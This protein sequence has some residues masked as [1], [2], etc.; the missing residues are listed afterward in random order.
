VSRKALEVVQQRLGGDVVEVGDHLGDAC[1]TVRSAALRKA[2]EIC[3]NDPAL[4]CDLL[5]D[6]VGVDH[7]RRAERFD[8]VYN[9][10]SMSTRERIRIKTSVAEDQAVPTVSDLW[11]SANWAEREVYDLFGVPF[12]DHPNLKRILC[13]HE[14][15]GHALRKD[16]PIGRGQMCYTPA[17]LLSDEEIEHGPAHYP[18]E[19][20][21]AA[22]SA[23]SDVAVAESDEE[24]RSDYLTVNIGPSHNATHGAL[25]IEALLDGETI[26]H[27][28]SEIGY[29]HRCFEKEAEDHTWTQII[30]Y[31]DRLN[32]VSAL[33]NNVGYVLAVEKMMGIRV[34]PRCEVIR[35]IVAEM[36]R[37]M[38]HLV[39]VGAN[40]VDLGALTNF[41]YFFNAREY[42]SDI[43]ERLCGERLTTSYTRIGGLYRDLYE[44]FEDELRH[45]L[46]KTEEAIADVTR[47]VQRNRILMDRAVGIGAVSAEEAVN[48]GFT[49]PCLRA[50]GVDYDVRKVAPYLGYDQYDFD[51][52]VGENGDTY[53]RVLVRIEEMFQS[54]GIVRQALDRLPDGPIYADDRRV[55]MPPKDEVY[56][57]IEGMMNHFKLVFEGI[58]V[59]AGEGYGFT[60]AANGEL[61]FY[62]VS[63]GSGHPYRI[64]V[65]PPCFP[66]FS[67]F[68]K[69]IQGRMVADAIA[70]LGSLNIIA[71]E[72]DR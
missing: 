71:G 20:E 31:T 25:R 9:L 4:R 39:C 45:A 53:D 6:V 8:V 48:W 54:I 3:K 49:G 16:Y 64:K 51:I 59:P 34:P 72:L 33:N 5:L 1:A 58:Q 68:T 40:L 63:D 50:S 13:H 67:T 22:R 47:L 38:D 14:F 21:T 30:P 29:L 10:R 27:S 32:Y 28:E 61:G 15:E 60:E 41:W 36:G 57:S 17:K 35:V 70:I 19:G 44:G 12:A 23:V 43:V 55:A 2:L 65:R 66:I 69:L 26:I 52:P 24:I 37:I 46:V 11:Y 56:N 7:P 18:R 62:I 42:F